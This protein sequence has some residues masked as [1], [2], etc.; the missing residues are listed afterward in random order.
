MRLNN[1]G[2]HLLTCFPSE[3][4]SS[5]TFCIGDLKRP[6]QPLRWREL[7]KIWPTT[8]KGIVVCECLHK[9]K[10]L[11]R[12]LSLSCCYRQMEGRGSFLI[13]GTNQGKIHA[14]VFR[15]L[16]MSRCSCPF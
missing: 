15:Y 10:N 16:P 6:V 8:K 13:F 11:T 14:R 9:R 4:K 7:L 2:Q 3:I 12:N 5:S 1:H